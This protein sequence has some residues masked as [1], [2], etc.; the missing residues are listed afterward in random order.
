[1]RLAQASIH[2]GREDFEH[3]ELPEIP[4]YANY[5]GELMR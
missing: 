3:T 1:M 5:R 4:D 2:A